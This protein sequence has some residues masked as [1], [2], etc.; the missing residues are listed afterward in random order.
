[1]A[2]VVNGRTPVKAPPTPLLETVDWR[3]FMAMT[4]QESFIPVALAASATL[5]SG[6]GTFGS[7]FCTTAGTFQ[8]TDASNNVLIPSVTLSAGQTVPGGYQ[9]GNGAKIVLS[10]GCAG[11]AS[12]STQIS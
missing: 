4:V 7:F 12:Y 1:M 3:P 6:P 9:C 5:F 10:G 8:L 11:T 2:A